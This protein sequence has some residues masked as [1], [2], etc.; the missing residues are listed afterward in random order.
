MM[1]TKNWGIR[2]NKYVKALAWCISNTLRLLTLDDR[3]RPLA[4]PD[5]APRG[6][7]SASL[8]PLFGGQMRA[9]YPNRATNTP[10]TPCCGGIGLNN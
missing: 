3:Q 5:A 1:F 9:G 8:F 4:R 6:A 10:S 7:A 2:V